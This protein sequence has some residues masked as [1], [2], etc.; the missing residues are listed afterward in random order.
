MNI[1]GPIIEIGNLKTTRELSYA[2]PDYWNHSISC[3]LCGKIDT[4]G[5]NTDDGKFIAFQEG[6]IEWDG[7]KWIVKWKTGTANYWDNLCWDCRH[8]IGGKVICRKCGKPISINRLVG[9]REPDPPFLFKP[10]LTDFCID[11]AEQLRQEEETAK[12]QKKCY[13]CGTMFDPRI[14]PR[15]YRGMHQTKGEYLS[16]PGQ[17]PIRRMQYCPSCMILKGLFCNVCCKGLAWN[18]YFDWRYARKIHLCEKHFIQYNDDPIQ[19]EY[20]KARTRI[21]EKTGIELGDI[22]IQ[23]VELEIARMILRRETRRM[24]HG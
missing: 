12:W 3:N 13:E 4:I 10:R 18:T 9:Y 16:H 6:G 24:K 14:F 1:N 20:H 2:C 23:F 7:K 21:R 11:C 17:P 19:L 15:F 22:P 8:R 5:G